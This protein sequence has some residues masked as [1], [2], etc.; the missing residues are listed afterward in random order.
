M[1]QASVLPPSTKRAADKFSR[2]AKRFARKAV[3]SPETA[4]KVLVKVGIY[5][6]DGTLTKKYK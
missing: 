3:K 2:D 5:K 6:S 4:R 1:S